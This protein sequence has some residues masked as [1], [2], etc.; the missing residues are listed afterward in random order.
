MKRIEAIAKGKS[1]QMSSSIERKA[2]RILRNV[3]QSIAFAED[4]VDELNDRIESI[5]DSLGEVAEADQ[6]PNCQRAINNY[7]DTVKQYRDWKET[8]EILNGLKAALD[9][10]VKLVEE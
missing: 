5:I 9:K 4:K 10:E 3:E 6:T 2:A 7:I 1:S 8:T